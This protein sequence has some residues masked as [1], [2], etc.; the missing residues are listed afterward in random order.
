[1]SFADNCRTSSGILSHCPSDRQRSISVSNRDPDF[2]AVIFL[3]TLDRGFR[4]QNKSTRKLLRQRQA[5]TTQRETATPKDK[6][7]KWSNIENTIPFH[8]C[9]TVCLHHAPASFDILIRQRHIFVYYNCFGIKRCKGSVMFVLAFE[10]Y[11][12]ISLCSGQAPANL[13]LY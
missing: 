9:W 6:K 8:L 2:L 3:Q 1:M 7:C 13:S 11:F 10:N 5:H 4:D 12:Q